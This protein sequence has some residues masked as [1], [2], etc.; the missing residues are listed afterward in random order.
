MASACRC[1]ICA[2]AGWW[3]WP[4]SPGHKPSLRCCGPAGWNSRPTEALP[5]HYDFNSWIRPSGDG[6]EVICTEKDAVK[7]WAAHP[8]VW[9]APL[10]LTPEPAFFQALDA[11]L[12]AKLSS[13][14]GHQTS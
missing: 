4:A 5:D 9:A 13:R 8:Q 3:P 12:E 11:Q 2:I 7:L 1:R 10:V 14:H 6:I